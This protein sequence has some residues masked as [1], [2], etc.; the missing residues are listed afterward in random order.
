MWLFESKELHLYLKKKL[1]RPD[2]VIHA[3]N[4]KTHKQKQM[5]PRV[6]SQPGLHISCPDNQGLY[7]KTVSQN[8]K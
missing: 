6:K 5:D 8:Q 3:F 7:S 4:P 2:I 1:I